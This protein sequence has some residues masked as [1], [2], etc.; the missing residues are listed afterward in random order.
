MR[1]TTLVQQQD[2]LLVLIERFIQGFLECLGEHLSIA[3]TELTRH[4]DDLDGWK[5]LSVRTLGH[6]HLMPRSIGLRAMQRLDGGRSRAQ[7]ERSARL[8]RH[9]FSNITRHIPWRL[10][11][12]VASLM[13]FVDDDDAH[14]RERCEERAART[15]HHTDRT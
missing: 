14:I 9:P 13:L 7:D 1:E 12:L 11:L 2:R 15:Y 3:A 5:R 4:V 8:A 6:D 10:V